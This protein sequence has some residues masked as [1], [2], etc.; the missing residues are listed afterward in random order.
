MYDS[1]YNYIQSKFGNISML[2]FTGIDSFMYEIKT[3]DVYEDCSK[4]RE[5]LDFS[6]YLPKSKYYDDSNKL[7][8]M[9]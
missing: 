4:D 7:L 9:K 2:L 8:V 1:R 5:T 6:N 3:E